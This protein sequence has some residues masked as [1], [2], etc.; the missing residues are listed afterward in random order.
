MI[1]PRKNLN[2][3]ETLLQ[4]LKE[5]GLVIMDMTK[6]NFISDLVW[7]LTMM[8]S[9]RNSILMYCVI[10]RYVLNHCCDVFWAVFPISEGPNKRIIRIWLVYCSSIVY[11]SLVSR[12]ALMESIESYLLRNSVFQCT[13]LT[14]DIHRAFLTCNALVK[15]MHSMRR[16]RNVSQK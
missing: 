10:L 1:M 8:Q 3:C 7:I 6:I 5:Q 16:V 14:S 12:H 11:M 13:I 4:F 9:I 15:A 2:I